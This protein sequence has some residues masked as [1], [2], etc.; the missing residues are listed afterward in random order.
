M[1][2]K[3]GD[4]C[5][6]HDTGAVF[7]SYPVATAIWRVK[8]E[9]TLRAPKGFEPRSFSMP[10]QLLSF[11]HF[12]HLP[13]PNHLNAPICYSLQ[14]VKPVYMT[15]KWC[16]VWYL[17]FLNIL[18]AMASLIPGCF[19][20]NSYR[21]YHYFTNLAR[22]QTFYAKTIIWWHVL[23]SIRCYK[24]MIKNWQFAVIISILQYLKQIYLFW[25]TV[26]QRCHNF[27]CSL[28]QQQP[29]LQTI[30]QH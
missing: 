4:W 6:L 11:N 22:I 10:L 5:G 9:L 18:L 20:L 30:K 16:H 3:P 14:Y 13:A 28:K 15:S 27:Y 7:S 8:A 19:I 24:S 25:Q 12:C 21:W 17:W 1:A 26:T 29:E 23:L 2:L